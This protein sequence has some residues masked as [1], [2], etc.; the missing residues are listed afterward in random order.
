MKIVAF[1]GMPFSGKTEAVKVAEDM[2]F[3]VVRMGDFVWDEV[4]KRGL[5]MNDKNVGNIANQMRN[6]FGKDVW[7]LKT[8]DKIKSMDKTRYIVIDGVRN[9]EEI[10][11]FKRELGKNFIVIAV[12]VPEIIRWERALKRHRIDDSI[13]IDL[14]KNRD[15]R[16]L[17]WG[18]HNVILSADIVI[19][20]EK[21]IS[22]FRK[23]I[24][25][26]LEML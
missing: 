12:E 14:I 16:E 3:P 6:K 9:I 18:L 25:K 24:K 23:R 20:N 17:G 15:L 11:T 2:K 1:T 13:D 26:V 4:K 10:D 22:N 19:S 8:I 21:S 7:A 5:K